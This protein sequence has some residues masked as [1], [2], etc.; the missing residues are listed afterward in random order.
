MLWTRSPPSRQEGGLRMPPS[1]AFSLLAASF[2]P[3]CGVQQISPAIKKSPPLKPRPAPGTTPSL[4]PPQP[5][6]WRSH[7][8]TRC[9]LVLSPHPCSGP[10]RAA[11]HP[12]RCTETV[13]SR[14][15]AKPIWHFRILKPANDVTARSCRPVSAPVFPASCKDVCGCPVGAPPG[16]SRPSH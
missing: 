1:S 2:P 14:S 11:S 7:T 5:H 9:L 8:C 6:F 3:A 10:L 16:Q 12:G 13:L 15:P 4:L